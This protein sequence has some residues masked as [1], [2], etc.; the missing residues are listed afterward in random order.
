MRLPAPTSRIVPY[1]HFAATVAFAALSCLGSVA[2]AQE[3]S[4]PLELELA[5]ASTT[6][7][8]ETGTDSRNAKNPPD[9]QAFL[10]ARHP[11]EIRR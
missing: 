1:L 8:L 9:T 11:G 2:F 10:L 4:S 6:A 3:V 5:N 7:L